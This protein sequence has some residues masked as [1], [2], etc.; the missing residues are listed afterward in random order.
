MQAYVL[1]IPSGNLVHEFLSHRTNIMLKP[2]QMAYERVSCDDSCPRDLPRREPYGT[3]VQVPPRHSSGFVQV[4]RNPPSLYERIDAHFTP[5][6]SLVLLTVCLSCCLGNDHSKLIT[7]LSASTM[8]PYSTAQAAIEIL[9]TVYDKYMEYREAD[10]TIANA[11]ACLDAV[12]VRLDLF[13]K[14]LKYMQAA[15]TERQCKVLQTSLDK[16]SDILAQ[17]GEKLPVKSTVSTKLTWAGWGRRRV[18][19]L[20]AEAKA[21]DQEAQ[22]TFFMLDLVKRLRETGVVNVDELRKRLFDTGDRTIAGA[23]TLSDRIYSVVVADAAPT[24]THLSSTDLDLPYSA[25]DQ[26]VYRLQGRPTY[27][28]AHYIEEGDEEHKRKQIS[29]CERL[30]YTFTPSDVDLSILHLLP[31]S[32]LVDQYDLDRCYVIYDLPFP[33]PASNKVPTLSRALEHQVRIT[34]ED[35]FR[36]AVEVAV[37]VFSIHAAGWVHKNIRSDNVLIDVGD[38][39][40]S[41][42]D[43][44]VVGTAFLVGFQATRPRIEGSEQRPEPD[45]VKRLY[46]HPERQG[47]RDTRVAKFD[48]RHDM[49]SLGAVLLEIGYRKTLREILQVKS[50]P[51]EPTLDEAKTNHKSLIKYAHRLAD[52]MGTKYTDATLA[53]LTKTTDSK[54]SADRLR[55]EFYDGVLQPLKQILEGLQGNRK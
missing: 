29:S 4:F 52:K 51:H 32:G 6:M 50:S 23:W 9:H 15:L 2:R 36:I 8:D 5:Q 34:L 14:C 19:A 39:D 40:K 42:K 17:L 22:G 44:A 13:E 24:V 38:V 30:A 12:D 10:E 37:A 27:L 20:I 43:T 33:L 35:R 41:S 16:V 46:Q 21:W 47:G 25:G 53:C 26:L 31:C 54:T 45:P 55:E 48:I 7:L 11:K 28:E 3:R 1:P 18:E 49:Y